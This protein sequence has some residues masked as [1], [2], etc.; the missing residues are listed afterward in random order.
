MN[1][2]TPF[3]QSSKSGKKK[4]YC[5]WMQHRWSKYKEKQGNDCHK[6]A[7]Q[8]TYG[9]VERGICLER[10]CRTFLAIQ[11]LRLCASHAGG[12]GLIPHGEA[13]VPYAAEYSQNK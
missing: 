12:V 7:I 4:V 8:V 13:K 11:Q 2:L 6:N 1:S 3:I 10:T 5:L 9:V